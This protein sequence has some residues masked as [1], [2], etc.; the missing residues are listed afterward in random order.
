MVTLTPT[1]KRVFAETCPIVA[2]DRWSISVY[3]LA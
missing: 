3:R 1:P 2:V